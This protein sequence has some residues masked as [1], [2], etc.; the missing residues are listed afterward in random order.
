M[1]RQRIEN[2][3]SP[4]VS[5]VLSVYNGEKY[6]CE[7]IGSILNQSFAD[8]ELIIVDDGS[9]DL[10]PEIIRSYKDPRIRV[11]R[12]ENQGLAYSLNRGIMAS[13]GQYIARMDDDDVS[14]PARLERQVAFLEQHPACGIVGTWAMNMT[15][16][17]E[18]LYVSEMPESDSDARRMLV[19]Q[20]PFY[21]GS[22]MF[23]RSL[24][25]A[26]GPYPEELGL[27]F[28][29]WVLFRRFAEK[30]GLANLGEVLYKFRLR[31]FSVN[32]RTRKQMQR[33]RSIVNR[34]VLTG[35]LLKGDEDFLRSMR[36]SLTPEKRQA[37]YYLKC[38]VIFLE[39]RQDHRRA[40][41]MLRESLALNPL[42]LK[43]WVNLGYCFLTPGMV[44][45]CKMLWKRL[46]GV[47]LELWGRI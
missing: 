20:S 1:N 13:R 18:D 41:Q 4:K 35:G 39:K 30:S 9:T 10:T 19:Y 17:G 7:A 21:H 40:R 29:D 3:K 42:S 25:E 5:V 24:F 15:E 34:F 6:L 44:A 16:E 26:A 22:V 37:L 33:L 31:P 12:H 28:E 14:L 43:G 46:K 23:R 38:G 2:T 27:F 47:D 36:T 45:R 11:L 32:N 8:F